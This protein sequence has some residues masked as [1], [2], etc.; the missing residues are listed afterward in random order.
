MGEQ[1]AKRGSPRGIAVQAALE[2]LRQLRPRRLGAGLKT[3]SCGKLDHQRGV[4]QGEE[5][6][7]RLQVPKRRS[8]ID[9]LVK[10][11]TKGPDVGLPAD[12]VMALLYGLCAI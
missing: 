11:D 6:L 10:D 9:H 7:H 2:D 3:A 12:L 8:A 1:L 5:A 4:V